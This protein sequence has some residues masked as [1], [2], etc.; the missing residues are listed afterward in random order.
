MKLPEIPGYSYD[1][2]INEGT[3]GYVYRCTGSTGEER[4]VKVLRTLAIDPELV[5]TMY[6]RLSRAPSHP[7]SGLRCIRRW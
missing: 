4:A 7:G 2:L 1:E 3:C 6:G 5:G